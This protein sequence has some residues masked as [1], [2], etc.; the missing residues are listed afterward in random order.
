[1]ALRID[2]IQVAGPV[3][4]DEDDMRCWKGEN[5]LLGLR[6]LS[7]EVGHCEWVESMNDRLI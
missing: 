3:E 4:R 2:T 6:G 1:M 5:R 7:S